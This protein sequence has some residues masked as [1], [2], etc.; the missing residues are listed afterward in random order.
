MIVTL[1][2]DFGSADSYVGAIKGVILSHDP[3]IR[4]VD[5]THEVAAHDVEEGAFLL[6]GAFAEFPPGTVHMAV[7]DPGV[8]SHRRGVA[9]QVGRYLLVGPD[10][11]IFSYVLERNGP[12]EAYAIENE[13]WTVPR[14]STTFHGRDIFAPTAA[15]LALGGR[16]EE[17]GP[18]IG[19]PVTLPSLRVDR[20]SDGSLRGRVLH[21]DRFGNCVTSF[22][23]EQ[24]AD[25]AGLQIRAGGAVIGEMRAFYAAAIGEGPFLI[26]GSGG[27]LEISVDRGNAARSLG[28]VRGAPLTLTLS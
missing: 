11:G 9:I 28:L 13:A 6:L 12:G 20:A 17:A 10:N 26:W 23:R 18:K 27:F 1:L 5:I 15:K 24:I 4:I 22:T 19:S 14:R 7:V 16:I 8:G 21:V 2:T 25:A 3:R